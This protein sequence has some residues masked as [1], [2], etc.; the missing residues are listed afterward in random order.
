[1]SRR[2]RKSNGAGILGIAILLALA[3]TFVLPAR[4]EKKKAGASSQA[5]KLSDQRTTGYFDISKIVWPNPPAITR[6][7]FVDLYTGQ[8]IDPN[9]F[10]K[11]T[12]PKQKWM[13]R[14]AGERQT[15]EIQVK[16][17]PFQLI[18][19]Y[20][21]AA[22]SKGQIYA[23]DQGVSAIFIF[24]PE[25]KDV[26]LIGNGKQAHFGA[27]SGL[28][29]DDNDRLFVTDVGMHRVDV[30]S[31]THE[32]ET[33]F[34]G[35]VLSTPSSIAIDTDN[36][37]LYV[38]DTQNDVVDV[39]DADSF[40]LLRKIG[41]PGK[42]HTLTAPG[43]F[44]LPT[45]VAVDSDGN[46]YVADTFNNRVEIFDADGKFISTFGKNGDGPQD[47]E[48]PKAIAVDCD[49]H[50]WVADGAQD[51][52]KV[53]N[54]E[55]RLL[56][57]FGQHGEYPGRFM[58]LNGLTIDK[59]NRVITSEQFPGR[60]QVFRYTTDA[61]FEAEKQKREGGAPS[62]AAATKAANDAT[63]ASAAKDS[64]VK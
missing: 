6:I 51:R 34:G 4:A 13:D 48:R 32:L 7:K 17:L 47:L 8:K 30:F 15:D 21:V 3:F 41:T 23:A 28:A 60:V 1:M 62:S 18:R 56:I 63:S 24:N 46:V 44:S 14:L 27:V 54:Q 42:K 22:D 26:Q 35:D 29:I 55:G 52:V 31:P 50:I 59:N 53:F 25:T 9:L 37:F 12:K 19:T 2:H 16:E 40:K 20:G 58:G 11:S 39:F 64:A 49:G 5:T 36:R 61:E 33:A 38:T 45:G 57:Y 43:T 10:K